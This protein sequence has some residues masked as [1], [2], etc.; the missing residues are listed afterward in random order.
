MKLK[1]I[2]EPFALYKPS[3][4]IEGKVIGAARKIKF[5][6]YRQRVKRHRNSHH[7]DRKTP[8]VLI[9]ANG[10]IG[11][12]V[13][14]TPLVEAVRMFWPMSEITLLTSAGYLF[15]NWCVPDRIN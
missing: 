1:P 6:I 14:A 3:K 2:L 11:N 5:N 9:A 12:A 7:L 10:G 4:W 13:E 8:R 15:E